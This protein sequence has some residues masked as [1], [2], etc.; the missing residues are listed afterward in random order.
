MVGS[1]FGFA[2]DADH[3]V[4]LTAGGGS[5]GIQLGDLASADS[6]LVV[7]PTGASKIGTTVAFNSTGTHVLYFTREDG[8]ED[9]I[10][11][12]AP[13]STRTPVTLATGVWR[14]HPIPGSS[15]V[16]FYTDVGEITDVV[17]TLHVIEP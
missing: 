16:F 4:M 10:L 17:S 2:P 1:Y 15:K 13:V 3:I 14:W 12:S 7:E 8:S 6:G 9:N 5:H 11:R